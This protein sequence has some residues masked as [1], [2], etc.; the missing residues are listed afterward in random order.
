MC[1]APLPPAQAAVLGARQQKNAEA[2]FV[3]RGA[4]AGDH[5]MVERHHQ[6]CRED[7]DIL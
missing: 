1:A 4:A 5:L 2:H 6:R 7:A 3:R